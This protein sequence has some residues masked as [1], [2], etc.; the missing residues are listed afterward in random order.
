MTISS[1]EERKL[2]NMSEDEKIF[3]A[4]G[5]IGLTIKMAI[6]PKAIYRFNAILIK[7]PTQLFTEFEITVLNFIWKNKKPRIVKMMLYN[8]KLL[9]VSPSLFQAVLQSYSNKILIVLAYKQTG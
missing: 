8:K 3:H 7:I 2:K 9:E 5:P 6:L 4:H 1:F